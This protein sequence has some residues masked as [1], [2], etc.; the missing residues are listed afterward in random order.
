MS[1]YNLAAL[2]NGQQFFTQAGSTPLVGGKIYSYFAGTTT[3]AA[4]YTDPTGATPNANPIII[5]SDGRP[6]SGGEIWIPTAAS[7]KFQVQDS[8]GV[9]QATYDNVLGINDFNYVSAI[10]YVTDTGN[11]NSYAGSLTS[12]LS[13]TAG[14][15]VELYVSNTSTGA[16]TLNL[17]GSGGAIGAATIV[18]ADGT[19]IQAGDLQ[20]GYI[21]F[22][23]YNA[24]AGKFFLVGSTNS[25]GFTILAGPGIDPT[26]ATDST[27]AI[28]TLLNNS[29]SS[30][31]FVPNGT[32]KLTS[33]LTVPSGK[34]IFGAG[35]SAIF[36]QTTASTAAF[37]ITNSGVVLQSFIINLTGSNSIGVQVGASLSLN[38]ISISGSNGGT[39]IVGNVSGITMSLVSVNISGSGAIGILASGITDIQMIACD[40]AADGNSAS[41]AFSITSCLST[42]R[43]ISCSF[44][45]LSFGSGIVI[46]APSSGV[47]ALQWVFTGCQIAAVSGNGLKLTSIKASSRFISFVNCSFYQGGSVSLSG[48]VTGSMFLF[49]GCN[50]S[51]STT[52][53]MSIASMAAGSYKIV[54]C[55]FYGNTSGA[56]NDTSYN[57]IYKNNDGI[58]STFTGISAYRSS[59]QTSGSTIIFDTVETGGLSGTYNSSTGVFTCPVDGFYNVTAQIT[60]AYSG[61]STA[62]VGGI[63]AKNGTGFL[64][65]FD[66]V[67]TTSGTASG[68]VS[69]RLQCSAGDTLRINNAFISGTYVISGGSAPYLTRLTITLD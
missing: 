31:Y 64:S 16:S 19:P 28:Q 17:T 56:V 57:G 53:G 47:T 21:A 54:N 62:G 13:Y 34:W 25:S 37:N 42:I 24:T 48:S 29:S 65:Q 14:L 50:F 38:Q 68:T 39:G 2:I 69:A 11:T 44:N 51:A 61:G 23:I 12:I 9:I 7:Y 10:N 63:L 6:A 52:Y 1:A 5:S 8:I 49:D 26:G 33:A 67:I 18:R 55:S 27:S 43:A 15:P 4:T 46:N 45:G 58:G 30:A 20:S 59:S 32:Y 36:N 60:V 66:G 41:T 35:S 40:I 22:M 3:P